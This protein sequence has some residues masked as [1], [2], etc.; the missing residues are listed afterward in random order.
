MANF[1]KYHSIQFEGSEMQLWKYYGIG[2]GIK[3]PYANPTFG[4]EG[5]QVIKEFSKTEQIQRVR[6]KVKLRKDRVLRN[7]FYCEVDGCSQTF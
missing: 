5:F 3:V 1:T 7:I 6:G 2:T 4:C